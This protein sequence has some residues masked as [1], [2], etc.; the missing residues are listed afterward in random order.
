MA[1]FEPPDRG[2]SSVVER[3]NSNPK[4]PGFDPLAGQGDNQFFYL[5]DSTFVHIYLCLPRRK[6][7]G[8]LMSPPVWN[9][10]AANLIPLFYISSIVI[11]PLFLF[12]P[13]LLLAHSPDLN[14]HF[15][16]GRLFCVT[17]VFCFL[18]G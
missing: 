11:L 2:C 17:L 7:G 12:Y 6:A 1:G 5:S 14:L 4:D 15:P 10:R 18:S 3:W 16:K 9:L 13:F 8:F